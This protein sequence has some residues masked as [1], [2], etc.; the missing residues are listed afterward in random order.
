MGMSGDRSWRRFDVVVETR[1]RWSRAEKLAIV[2]EALR[3]TNVSAVARR[4]GIKPS[5]LFRWKKQYGA[6]AGG[7]APSPAFVPL[8]L[9]AP[10]SPAPPPEHTGSIEIDL[11]TGRRVRVGTRVDLAA[12]KRIIEVLEE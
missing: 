6:P 8:A 3:G 1:R 10:A 2:E 7:E 4:H 12:L 9:P 11:R 5:L